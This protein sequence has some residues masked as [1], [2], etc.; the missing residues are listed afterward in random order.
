M[1]KNLFGSSKPQIDPSQQK[2][3]EEERGK[4]EKERAKEKLDESLKKTDEKLDKVNAEIAQLEA[5]VKQL[6]MQKRKDKAAV[7][8]K[9]LKGKKEVAIK[10]QK[11][12]AFLMKQT[13]L[14]EDTE[15]DLELFETMKDVNKIN[16]KNRD[17]QDQLRDELALAKELDDEA[18]MRRDE[19]NDLMDDDEDQD[20]LDDMMKQYEQEA[21]EELKM[22][23]DK[24]DNKILDSSSQ[25]KQTQP[26]AA[27]KEDNF[28][29]L[30]AELMN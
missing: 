20:D 21:N 16:Q 10:Y 24:A 4:L 23:F 26:V 7:V 11:Q 19:L 30:M 28:D 15:A 8:L 9:K 17:Q 3:I 6:I 18:K 12:S 5:E 22:G 1:F 29:N 25:K 2:R 13:G 14:L 27:R